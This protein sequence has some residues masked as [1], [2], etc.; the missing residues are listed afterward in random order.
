MVR[1]RV[2][3]RMRGCR[4]PYSRCW[5]YSEPLHFSIAAARHSTGDSFV[6]AY[7]VPANR[8]YLQLATRGGAAAAARA[9]STVGDG[10]AAL[11]VLTL[12]LQRVVLWNPNASV[13][14]VAPAWPAPV[15]GH[16]ARHEPHWSRRPECSS[17]VAVLKRRGV[18]EQGCRVGCADGGG[19][20]RMAVV[21][22]G[23]ACVGGGVE[24]STGVDSC[25]LV[26]EGEAASRTLREGSCRAG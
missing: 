22:G 20:G 13:R 23:A 16:A 17:V 12:D 18:V 2:G 24:G 4:A 19:S 8:P 11:S 9:R 10:V 7:P 5:G 14:V 1:R 3:G 25:R 6:V 15:R 26:E 21:Q